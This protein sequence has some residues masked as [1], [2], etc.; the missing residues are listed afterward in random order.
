[1]N[2]H[3]VNTTVSRLTDETLE[4]TILKTR[5]REQLGIQVRNIYTLLGFDRPVEFPNSRDM[6]CE[7]IRILH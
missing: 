6:I 5:F 1:M 7:K 4:T 3:I 2:I